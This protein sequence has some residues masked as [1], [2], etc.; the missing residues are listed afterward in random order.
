[1]LSYSLHIQNPRGFAG[2]G[3]IIRCLHH[4]HQLLHLLSLKV[5]DALNLH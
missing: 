2:R 1:M 4:L 3:P 5:T